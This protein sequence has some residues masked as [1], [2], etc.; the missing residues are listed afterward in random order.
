MPEKRVVFTKRLGDRVA[1]KME[2]TILKRIGWAN[3]M[4]ECSEEIEIIIDS[5]EEDFKDT[6]KHLE[7]IA[8]E[9]EYEIQVI[10]A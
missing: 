9:N 5:P 2:K 3:P 7:E 6:L 1:K 4:I 10:D 8:K